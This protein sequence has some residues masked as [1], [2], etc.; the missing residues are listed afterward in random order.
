MNNFIIGAAT[1]PGA[2]FYEYYERVEE[3]DD[4]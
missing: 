4:D 1:F 2:E 3:K